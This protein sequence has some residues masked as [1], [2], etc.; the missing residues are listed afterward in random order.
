MSS[1]AEFATQLATR[2]DAVGVTIAAHPRE[3][4]TFELRGKDH[5]GHITNIDELERFV[6]TL[7]RF[8]AEL[9]R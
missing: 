2:A 8:H 6:V 1:I 5:I 3:G 9:C 7:E 4:W